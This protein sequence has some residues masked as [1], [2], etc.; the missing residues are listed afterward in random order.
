ASGEAQE[1]L[2][3]RDGPVKLFKIL[4]T[5]ESSNFL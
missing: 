5:P 3:L 4:P 2:S 1:V